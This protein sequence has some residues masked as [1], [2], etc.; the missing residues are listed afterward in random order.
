ME[1]LESKSIAKCNDQPLIEI[2]DQSVKVL[3]IFWNPNKGCFQFKVSESDSCPQN[4]LIRLGPC[5]S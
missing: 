1:I 4:H 5:S 2:M 3:G